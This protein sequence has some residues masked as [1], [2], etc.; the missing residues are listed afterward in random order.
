MLDKNQKI[1][2]LLYPDIKMTVSDLLKMYPNRVLKDGAHVTRIAPSPTGELHMGQLYQAYINKQ[3]AEQS[4]GIFYLRL[5]DTDKKREVEGAG[6]KIYPL[7]K[8]FE[9]APDEG[10]VSKSK[11]IGLYGPYIQSF[12]KE[13]YQIF[14]KDLVSRGLAYPCF[15]EEGQ[16][17]AAKEEQMRLGLP[18]GY[19]GQWAKCRDLT[20]E[21]VK[22]RL[23]MGLSF[24]IR[25]RAD[26]DGQRRIVVRDLARG[27]ISFPRNF[28]DSVLIK[29]DGLAVYHM[30]HLVDDTLMHTT[31]VIRGEDWLSSLPLHLQLFEYMG[32]E[33]P[34]YLHTAQIM[35]KDAETGNT[36]K[37][38]KRYDPWARI[39]WFK[40]QGYPAIGLKEYILN[41]INSTFEPWR[42]AN[43]RKPIS[44]FKLS[45]QNMQ[46]SGAIFDLVKL[47][48]VCKNAISLMS[49]EEIY[50]ETLNWAKEYDKDFAIMLETH[51]SYMLKVFS[52]DKSETRPRKDIKCWSEIKNFYSYMFNSIFRSRE[53]MLDFDTNID[54]KEVVLVLEEYLRNYVHESDNQKWF[55]Y[56]KQVAQKCGYSIDVKEYKLNP[57][58]FKGSV[59]DVAT[60]IRVAVTG[61]RKT[62]NLCEIEQILGEEE[63][64]KRIKESINAIK[65]FL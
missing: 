32:L 15:C 36:R 12:R 45:F 55:E 41:L 4:E 30:A 43:P 6:D 11:E 35:T 58:Q 48:N 49:G 20:Y 19:Y 2:E 53:R 57:S 50:N 52:M 13:Y 26:G 33:A 60:I 1:A 47:E 63:T 7:L 28:V 29:S 17:A 21:Q 8:Y 37:I 22:E 62:P 18:T 31:T 3:L 64:R 23:D 14:A 54:L 9:L 5:E 59:T 42:R 10:Y 34:D 24:T 27:K 56:I 25:I 65:M 39:E 38:S 40:E 61:Q 46:K 16:E 51:K 44:E